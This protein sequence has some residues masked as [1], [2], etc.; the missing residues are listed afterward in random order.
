M[1]IADQ[2]AKFVA[3]TTF[4]DIPRETVSFVKNLSSKI[5]AAMLTGSTTPAGIKTAEY[6]NSKQGPAEVGVIGGRISL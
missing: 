5:I 4:D 3:E 1:A 6:V 2:I